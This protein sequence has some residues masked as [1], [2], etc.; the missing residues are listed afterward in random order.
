MKIE[1]AEFTYC[2]AEMSQLPTSDKPEIAFAGRS[3]VGKSSLINSLLS[4]KSL[5][6]TSGKPG[7]TQTLNYYL[8]N[9]SFYLVDLPG[10]GFA[11]VPQQIRKRWQGLLEGYLSKRESLRA[12]ILVVDSRHEPSKLDLQMYNWL[13]HYNKPLFVVATKVDK[14]RSSQRSKLIQGLRDAFGV[15]LV[16]HSSL[17][18]GSQEEIWSQ[19][20]KLL[21]TEQ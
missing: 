11:Q 5:A 17:K 6:R 8:V 13:R 20:E 19:I 12:V 21:W 18:G 16:P 1:S 10:Y 9:D 2:V 7:K 3:N 4:R 14:L 15:F